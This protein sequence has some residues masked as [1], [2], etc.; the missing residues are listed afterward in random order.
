MVFSSGYVGF[1]LFVCCLW[2]DLVKVLEFSVDRDCVC[3]CGDLL[4]LLFC[5]C[6]DF[7]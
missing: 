2:V 4:G 1:G 7:G 5:G 6:V 3:V